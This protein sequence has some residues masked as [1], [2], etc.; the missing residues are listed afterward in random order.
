MHAYGHAYAPAPGGG[1]TL[2]P[3]ARV[4]VGARS[5]GN[6]IN[7]VEQPAGVDRDVKIRNASSRLEP[8]SIAIL[9]CRPGLLQLQGL[10]KGSIADEASLEGALR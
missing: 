2:P 1:H 7:L 3:T 4:Q 10:G 9:I 6:N 5:T 8:H